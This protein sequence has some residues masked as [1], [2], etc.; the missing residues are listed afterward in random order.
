MR[1]GAAR[2]ASYSATALFVLIRREP[3]EVPMF[4]ARR[5]LIA[6][7][8]ITAS[9]AVMVSMLV[10]PPAGAA[11]PAAT[12]C[13]GRPVTVVA[14][15]SVTTGTEGDDVVAMTPGGW[16]QFDALGGNDTICMAVPAAIGGSDPWPP[17]GWVEAGAGNDMVMD[18]SEVV[19]G[20][21]VSVGLGAGDDSFTGNGLSERVFADSSI[22]T[23]DGPVPAGTQRDLIDSGAGADTVYTAAV[24]GQLNADRIVF[25]A[26][27]ATVDYRGAM[28]PDGVLDVSAATSARL[29]VPLPGA[30]LPVAVGELVVDNAARRATVGGTTVL[31]WTGEIRS[32]Q[33]GRDPG[34][35]S[36]L[37]VSFIGTDA[38]EGVA[39]SGGPIGDV[40]FGAGD[41]YLKVEAYNDPFVPRSL[42]GGPGSDTAQIDTAC[43]VLTVVVDETV[44]CDGAPGPLVGVE[45]VLESS[46][47]GGS[48]VTLIGTAR[49][50]RL[51]AIGDRVTVRGRGGDDDILVDEGWTTRV[52]GGD[53]DDRIY[54]E[55]DDV[56]VR[57]DAGADRIRLDGPLNYY[58]FG[59]KPVKTGQHVAQGGRGPDVL[60]GSDYK[61]ADRLVG[62]RGRDRADGRKGQRDFCLAEVTRR[63]ERPSTRR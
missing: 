45:E 30:A 33:L 23:Y 48:Q 63:C 50:E 44:A 32:F 7:A 34:T 58:L 56:V 59:G 6:A 19:A 9:I 39:V 8:T 2:G 22:Q 17:T 29:Q 11:Q 25:G 37:P 53:G 60:I 21:Q 41:D 54:V 57:G 46:D 26:G 20:A 36:G 15:S 27:E 42:D 13:L 28:G 51:V 61:V 16:N 55:G 49:S 52:R 14:S 1:T 40:R 10:A 24:E 62:G 4:R 43:L 38:D 3:S 12:T 35:S 47:R 31:T 18:E 5:I